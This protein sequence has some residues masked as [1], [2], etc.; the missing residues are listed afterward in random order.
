RIAREKARSGWFAPNVHALLGAR[1]GRGLRRG[2][3]QAQ[4]EELRR[5]KLR[6]HDEREQRQRELLLREQAID[7]RLHLLEAAA[8]SAPRRHCVTSSSG[9]PCSVHPGKSAGVTRRSSRASSF[10]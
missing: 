7:E 4:E 8:S 9:A 3:L 6:H 10:R 5:E 2:W 1:R